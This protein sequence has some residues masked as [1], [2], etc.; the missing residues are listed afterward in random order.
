MPAAAIPFSP[1]SESSGRLLEVLMQRRQMQALQ[2]QGGGLN[3]QFGGGGDSSSSLAAIVP[4]LM[5]QQRSEEERRQFDLMFPLQKEQLE[6]QRKTD[7]LTRQMMEQQQLMAQQ[8]QKF[9]MDE[10]EAR[11]L[12]ATRMAALMQRQE[13]LPGEMAQF[14]SAVTSAERQA[15]RRYANAERGYTMGNQGAADALG[16]W[17]DALSDIRSGDFDA[18]RIGRLIQSGSDDLR[19]YLE[20]N[21]G[22]DEATRQGIGAALRQAKSSLYS[23]SG[24]IEDEADRARVR[25]TLDSVLGS[26]GINNFIAKN[27]HPDY[28]GTVRRETETALDRIEAESA[29]RREAAQ[30]TWRGGMAEVLNARNPDDVR[31]AVSNISQFNIPTEGLGGEANGVQGSMSTPDDGGIGDLSAALASESKA[32]VQTDMTSMDGKG[33]LAGARAKSMLGS[34]FEAVMDAREPIAKEGDKT[35]QDLPFFNWQNWPPHDDWASMDPILRW[36]GGIGP[37]NE[38]PPIPPP[39][40]KVRHPDDVPYRYSRM[41]Q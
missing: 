20:Q 35:L 26:A 39:P 4:L 1:G 25:D 14:Q 12:D 17:G 24:R 30:Q 29:A 38:A 6:G 36:I 9:G 31:S 18:D 28:L 16:A 13:V 8:Q 19:M 23:A 40:P 10:A 21:G 3:M 5:A 2:R 22:A 37:S 27:A 11:R 7:E 15:E 33:V 32:R 41:I 34:A